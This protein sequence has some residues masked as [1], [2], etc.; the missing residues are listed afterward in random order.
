MNEIQTAATN[1]KSAIA[2]KTI[3][4]V[5]GRKKSNKATLNSVSDKER[6]KL[7]HTHFKE[8][9]GK[10]IQSILHSENSTKIL[11]KLEIK[12]RPFTKE[13]VITVTTYISYRQSV[14][15]DEIPAEVWKLEDFKE[16][17]LESCNRVHLQEPIARWTY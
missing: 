3:N 12:T 11:N 2:L 9:L 5:S 1:K 4:E 16:F 17:L 15:L 6:F 8:L 7:W 13:D 14:G 10:N